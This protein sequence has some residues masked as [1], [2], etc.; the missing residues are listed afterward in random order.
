ME[1]S[2]SVIGDVLDKTSGR[3]NVSTYSTIQTVKYSLNAKTSHTFRPKS[4]QIF[5]RSDRLKSQVISKDVERITNSKKVSECELTF[6]K[7]ISTGL[8]AE[9]VTKKRVLKTAL[10]KLLKTKI[11]GN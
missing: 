7:T 5:Q 9:R 1:S 3:M 4:F 2:F 10:W 6:S 8:T 11:E